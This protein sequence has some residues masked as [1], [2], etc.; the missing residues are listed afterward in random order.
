MSLKNFLLDFIF[1][2]H[3]LGCQKELLSN[4]ESFVCAKCFEKITLNRGIQC[5]ICGLRNG[6]GVCPARSGRNCESKTFLKAIFSA[7]Y[8]DDPILKEAIRAFKYDSVE[9]LKK[10]LSKIIIKYIKN[11]NLSDH[12]NGAILVPIPLARRRKITRGFNQ[13]ELLANKL[14]PIL[15]C[16]VLNLLKRQKF[17]Q[18]QAEIPEWEKRKENVSGIF[19]LNNIGFGNLYK[20]ILVDD[21]STSGATLEEAASVLKQAGVKEVYGLVV[22]K[23]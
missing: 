9:S 11:E 13:S 7:G 17:N 4:E 20:V 18:P 22:A 1:P 5:H 2:R 14:S 8:Y 16:P 3:C 12:L 19:T 23:G 15:N 21:V 10:P 6:E